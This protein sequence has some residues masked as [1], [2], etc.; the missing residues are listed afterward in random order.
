M[1]VWFGCGDDVVGDLLYVDVIG[2]DGWC[3]VLLS[4]VWLY[5][6]YVWCLMC[7]GV[8]VVSRLC[9]VVGDML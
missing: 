9:D 7:V 5:I 6:Y 1:L 2:V 4:V 3:R 8:F